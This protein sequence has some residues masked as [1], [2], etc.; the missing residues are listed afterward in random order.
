MTQNTWQQRE[1]L[2]RKFE[3]KEKESERGR[4]SE[5]RKELYTCS[6]KRKREFGVW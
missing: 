2:I 3:N 4:E 1:E 6:W 5:R